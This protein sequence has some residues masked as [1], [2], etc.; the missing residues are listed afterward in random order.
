MSKENISKFFV[1]TTNRRLFSYLY[2]GSKH[3]VT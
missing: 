3:T 2:I 1:P